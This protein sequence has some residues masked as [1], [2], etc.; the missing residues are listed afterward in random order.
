[1][2]KSTK[3]PL[4]NPTQVHPA[5]AANMGWNIQKMNDSEKVTLVR[6]RVVYEELVMSKSEFD[7]M[8]EKT[9]LENWDNDEEFYLS[10]LEM[11]DIG[12]PDFTDDQT[13]YIAFPGD[14]TSC[15]DDAIAFLYQNQ[16]WIDGFGSEHVK[17]AS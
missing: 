7:A 13:Q 12:F 11:K 5:F 4:M 2:N 1:M 8:N 3:Q 16:E 17:I 15:T 9:Y 14:V 6:R 10:E